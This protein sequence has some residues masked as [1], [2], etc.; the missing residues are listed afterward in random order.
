M[1]K[2]IILLSFLFASCLHVSVATAMSKVVPKTI[3]VNVLQKID[4]QGKPLWVVEIKEIGLDGTEFEEWKYFST[5]AEAETA[6]AIAK[7]KKAVKPTSK[8]ARALPALNEEDDDDLLAFGLPESSSNTKPMLS[9]KVSGGA[10]DFT[11]KISSQPRQPSQIP[12]ITLSDY[13]IPSAAQ[14]IQDICILEF[15]GSM[16]PDEVK[17]LLIKKGYV[18]YDDATIAKIADYISNVLQDV[19]GLADVMYQTLRNRSDFGFDSRNSKQSNEKYL[20]NYLWLQNRKQYIS[21]DLKQALMNRLAYEKLEKYEFLKYANDFYARVMQDSRIVWP[22]N[23]K[24]DNVKETVGRYFQYSQ[25]PKIVKLRNRIPM[26][27]IVNNSEAKNDAKELIDMVAQKIA[28]PVNRP[29]KNL[30]EQLQ[31]AVFEQQLEQAQKEK[32][33]LE[34]AMSQRQAEFDRQRK[35]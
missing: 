31:Q 14:K 26:M 6:A 28:L 29:P 25:D 34:D 30:G 7:A 27:A 22:S 35:K 4:Q 15:T 10:P 23:L 1:K 20:K 12:K 16:S 2:N 11:K 8:S 33:R 13:Q 17:N 18:L 19:D 9:V 24:L 21:D 32:N 3:E 5:K